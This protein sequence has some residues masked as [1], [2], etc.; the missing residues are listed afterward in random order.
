MAIDTFYIV[1]V[2]KAQV[3]DPARLK[4]L[5]AELLQIVTPEEAEAAAS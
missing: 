2:T 3:S 4:L 5:Q 1:D